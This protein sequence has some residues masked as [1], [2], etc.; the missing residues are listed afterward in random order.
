MKCINKKKLQKLFKKPEPNKKKKNKSNSQRIKKVR[1]TL[2]FMGIL[3]AFLLV[4]IGALAFYIRGGHLNEPLPYSR[5]ERVFGTSLQESAVIADGMA[6]DLCVGAGDNALDGVE[7]LDG[8]LAGFFDIQ[9]GDI[10]FA[11]G[12]YEPASA[13]RLVQLM[14]VLTAWENLDLETE[15]TIEQEDLPYSLA[16]TCGLAAGNVIPARQLLN[17][18]IV[19]S[20]QDACMVLAKAVSGSESAFVDGMN[21]KA[22]ELGMT[23]THYTNPT[24]AE[25]EEQ[26]TSVYDTYLL[27]NA[28]RKHTELTNALGASSYTLDYSRADGEVK[29]QRLDS[30]N[31][32]VTG[33]VSPPK[34]VTILGG[35]M[36]AS[37]YQNYAALLAQDNY[38]NPY[39]F[40]VLKTSDQTNLYERMEQMMET[41]RS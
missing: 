13:G 5:S 2:I 19:S 28:I 35:K 3:A 7:G 39:V 20:A 9:E 16:Q 8:E 25:D 24:G 12:I 23:N 15:V 30:D 21:A 26:Y 33:I 1:K 14:T 27:L 38:G 18:V 41:I 31:L 6:R 36:Y 34:G 4:G 32:Y 40:I 10:P 29:Q 37:E 17:A 22:K 11:Q